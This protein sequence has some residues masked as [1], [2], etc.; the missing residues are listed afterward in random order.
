MLGIKKNVILHLHEVELLSIIVK[1]KLD[2][3]GTDVV[4]GLGSSN[5]FRA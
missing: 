1:Y 2:G 4:Y 3:S 5:S